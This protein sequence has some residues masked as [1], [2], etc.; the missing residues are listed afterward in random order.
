M[1]RLGS[2]FV[3]A[4]D[5]PPIGKEKRSRFAGHPWRSL[6]AILGIQ[7]ICYT[8]AGFILFHNSPKDVNHTEGFQPL[9]LSVTTLIAYVLSPFFLGIPKGK[10]SFLEYLDDIRLTKM[11]PFF[12]LLVLTIS[13]DLILILC[14]GT[15]SIVYRLTEGNPVTLEFVARV[16]DLSRA[17]PPKSMLVFTM[18]F[19]MFEEVAFRGILITMLLE[20]HSWVRAI[21]Y[22][23]LAFGAAHFLS[24]LAGK[25]I[26]HTLGQVV[27]AF[28]FGLFYG[29]IFIK[30][31]SL[32][33]CMIIH[34]LSNVFQ[35]PLTEYWSKASPEISALYG[36]VFGYGLASFLMILWVH[37]FS[38]RWLTAGKMNK[39]QGVLQQPHP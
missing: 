35:A 22:S 14:Q 31:G 32:I 26:L 28:L 36:V 16:F 27:W 7:G 23:A 25:E 8:L 34:W 6:L 29:Y 17:L 15:G 18:F 9:L 2:H 3:E 20:K 33:P 11:R 4:M 12:R 5:R 24:I 30:S 1:T 38:N 10:R 39:T 21:I 37:Y 19:S 13:C